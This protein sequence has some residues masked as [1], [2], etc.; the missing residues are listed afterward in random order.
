MDSFNWDRLILIGWTDYN[1]NTNRNRTSHHLQL[2]VTVGGGWNVGKEMVSC[3]NGGFR[4][5][6]L[7]GVAVQKF[8]GG[9]AELK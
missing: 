9:G 7:R 2:H 6:D 3:F 8:V 1:R 5:P 4:G